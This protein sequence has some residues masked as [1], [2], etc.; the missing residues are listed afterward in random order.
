M[1]DEATKRTAET[2]LT[3]GIL[4]VATALAEGAAIRLKFMFRYPGFHSWYIK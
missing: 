4:T 3:R 1:R 2:N